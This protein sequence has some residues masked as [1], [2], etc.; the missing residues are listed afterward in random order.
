MGLRLVRKVMAKTELELT[1]PW[2]TR[3]GYNQPLVGATISAFVGI[4]SAAFARIGT[5]I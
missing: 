4:D 3:A 1:D 2:E 5:A